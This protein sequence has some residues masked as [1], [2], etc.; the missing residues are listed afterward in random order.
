MRPISHFQPILKLDLRWPLTLIC[1][2]WPHQ[3]IRVPMLHLWPNFGWNPSKHVE[4]RAKCNTFS[5]QTTTTSNNYY[6]SGQSD[7][8]V[9][10]L[11]RQ[12]TQK[13]ERERERER[14]IP[15]TYLSCGKTSFWSEL[16]NSLRD[17]ARNSPHQYWGLHTR[18]N[19]LPVR[20]RNCGVPIKHRCLKSDLHVSIFNAEGCLVVDGHSLSLPKEYL[21]GTYR[22]D[23]VHQTKLVWLPAQRYTHSRIRGCRG[24]YDLLRESPYSSLHNI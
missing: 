7:P 11:L 8:Y 23:V 22:K 13:R 18:T 17:D 16:K 24:R 19:K 3:Q 21:R 6:Y 4:V 2:L 14:E 9:S 10:F 1:D 20:S 15:T 5:Q 12:T